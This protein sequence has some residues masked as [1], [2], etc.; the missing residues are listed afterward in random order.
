MPRSVLV[1]LVALS[2]ALLA[3]GQEPL[4]LKVH[5]GWVGA[6]AF[7]PD[8]KTL[9]SGSAVQP[10]AEKTW[11]TPML[12]CW[13]A[14]TGELK[15]SLGASGDT[16]AAV[17]Y[18]PNGKLVATG[19]FNGTAD[20]WDPATHK[21]A[22]KFLGDQY[23]GNKGHRGAV[24]CVAFSADSATLATGGIDG[25]IRF[26]DTNTEKQKTVIREHKSWVN[27]L[28]YSPDGTTLASGSSDNTVKLWDAGTLKETASFAERTGE[29]RSL[30]FS[31]DGKTLA[32][33]IRYGVVRLLDGKTA[34]E[35]ANWKAHVSDVWAVAFTPDGKTLATGNGDWD[36]PGEV[37]LWD[38]QSL[39]ER[40]VLK[41]TGEVLALA[42]SA[43]GKLA[44][45]SWDR[46]IRLWDLNKLPNPQK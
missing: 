44:A 22:G 4:V 15:W 39:K 8:G 24:M 26:W 2:F 19:S 16:I 10:G 13:D 42:I 23:F 32:V 5:K 25:T 29:V 17:A 27:A 34:K 33:G 36:R 12:N 7:S 41:H 30:A 28:V 14:A 1:F 37:K 38:V 9:L 3:N 6:V 35:K 21:G 20:L 18:S 43:D 31:P 11:Q 40:A 46:T 45:G